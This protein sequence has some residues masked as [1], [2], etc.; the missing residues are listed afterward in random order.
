MK[1]LLRSVIDLEGSIDQENLTI[2]LKR[3]TESKVDW[4]RPEDKK[5][6]EYVK[7]YFYT[8]FEVPS[9]ITVTDYFEKIGDEEVIERLKDVR[10]AQPYIR[11]NFQHLISS[12]VEEQNK[13][14]LIELLQQ[15]R[16]IAVK[17]VTLDGETYRG[18]EDALRHFTSKASQL[19]HTDSNAKTHFVIRQEGQEVW[20]EYQA[21]KMDK[22]Q[23]YGVL[24]GLNN[25][26]KVIKGARKGDLWVHAAFTS[27]LKTTFAITWSYNLV[28]RYR[29][30][31][32]YASFEMKGE[33]LRRIFYTMHS[34]HARWKLQGYKPLDYEKVKNGLMSDEEE[35]FYQKVIEDFTTNPDYGQLTIW[36][37]NET[38]TTVSEVRVEAE[39]AHRVHP[40]GLLVLDQGSLMAAEKNK[41][42]RD[43]NQELNSVVRDGKKLAMNFNSG[44]G[45]PTLLLFQINREGWKEAEKNE[46]RYR[47]TA[48][49]NANEAE[50][51]ADI[52]TTTYL[53]DEHRK[54]WTTLICHL[55]N[56]DGA[57]FSPFLASVDPCTRRII[58]MDPFTGQSGKGITIEDHRAVMLTMSDI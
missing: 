31:V 35:A 11:S 21:A 33:H 18:N 39:L 13:A 44:E 52:V 41:R 29:Q 34:S 20:N 43:T 37:P 49:A 9:I 36:S 3:L 56:R 51:S 7:T 15:T 19:L 47:L 50:R 16:D 32:F 4:T 48:L 30:N 54:N 40:I 23:A 6:F 57:F 42:F 2:N 27:Q 55:K 24:T 10:S 28:T 22:S 45:V 38:N 46:G 26:D 58:N 25:I 5:L 14:K 1:R 17:G 12:I 53:N 8:R